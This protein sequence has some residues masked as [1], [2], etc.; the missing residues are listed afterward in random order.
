MENYFIKMYTHP[1]IVHAVTRHVVDYYLEAN[2][3]L[4]KVAGD[5]IDGYFFGNDFGTQLDLLISPQLFEEFIVL[6]FQE[7]IATARAEGYQVILHSCG[8]VHRI[9]PD[10]MKLGIDA[11]HPLQAKARNMDAVTLSGDFGGKLAFIGGIDTQDL[12]INA[13]PG[14]IV[15]EVNR[16]KS[17]LGPRLIISPSHECLLPNIPP[18]NVKAM[19]EANRKCTA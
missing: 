11:L 7:L 15:K 19:A 8:A 12:L 10:F 2:R 14:E 6:Y 13:T 4:F 18:A 3:R 17:L 16:V 1:E 9:I 5:L